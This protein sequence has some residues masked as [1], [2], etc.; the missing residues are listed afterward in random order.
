MASRGV[1]NRL[2]LL[3]TKSMNMPEMILKMPLSLLALVLIIPCQTIR[4]PQT[5]FTSKPMQM[6]LEK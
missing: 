3:Q 5:E 2:E 4:I 6:D 1:V